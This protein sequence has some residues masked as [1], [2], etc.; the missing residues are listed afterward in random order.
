[1]WFHTRHYQAT[2]FLGCTDTPTKDQRGAIASPRDSGEHRTGEERRGERERE[3]RRDGK[4]RI[5]SNC[6]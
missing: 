2:P 5:S 3:G 6:T 4:E 1:M